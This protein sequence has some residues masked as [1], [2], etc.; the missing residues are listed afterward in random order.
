[1]YKNITGSKAKFL[2]DKFGFWAVVFLSSLLFFY[3][4]SGICFPFLVGFT[5]AYL[6]APFVNLA[7]KYINRTVISFFLAVGCVFLFIAAAIEI[8]P[9]IKEYLIFI[10]N[11]TPIYYDRFI[12]FLDNTFSSVDFLQYK[13][14]I[15]SMK[16][17]I[18]KFL[19]QKIYI[20]ASIIG[21][22]ASKTE[23]ISRFFSFCVIMPISFFYFLKDWNDMVN[24]IYSCI[25]NRQR[26]IVLETS[27]IVRKTFAKFFHGQFY[28]VIALSIYYTL[29]LLAIGLSNKVYLGFISGLLSFIPF[30]GAL[31]SCVLVIFISV[32]AMT[33]TKLSVILIIYAI[34]QFV[35]GYILYPR[36]VGKKTGLHPLWILFSFFAGIQLEGIIGVLVAIPLAA[37]I[38]NLIKL[39]IS[40]FKASQMYKQ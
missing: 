22:I 30:I 4:F 12:S 25:P 31:F 1:M 21:E 15:A 11:N 16:L 6:C 40:K 17:E 8:L 36:F 35:E 26:R 29:M 33:M 18:Q 24:Y 3:L 14:E 37:V 7:S 34:G 23:I 27:N 2:Q 39:A 28:V 5:L 10:A 13:S 32:P 9:R 19:N 38:R 20:L